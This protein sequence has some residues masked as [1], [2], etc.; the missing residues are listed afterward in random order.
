M[1]FQQYLFVLFFFSLGKGKIYDSVLKIYCQ[2]NVTVK[3]TKWQHKTL[4]KCSITQRLWNDLGQSVGEIQP[5]SLGL[6]SLWVKPPTQRN[7]CVISWPSICINVFRSNLPKGG[8][9]QGKIGNGIPFFKK[10]LLQTGGYSNKPAVHSNDLEACGNKCCC[11][12]S[13]PKS[14]FWRVHC[15][16]VSVSETL[17]LLFFSFSNTGVWALFFHVISTN[18]YS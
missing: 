16:Q 2:T 7:I 11:F 10:L 4:P 9:R 5:P 3:R 1:F 13:M 18:A 14:K 15:T 12:G 8:S 6:T 17:A